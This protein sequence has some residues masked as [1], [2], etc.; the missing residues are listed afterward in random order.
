MN[1]KMGKGDHLYLNPGTRSTRILSRVSVD[2]VKSEACPR[3][4]APRQ[5]QASSQESLRILSTPLLGF[6]SEAS[7][8][9]RLCTTPGTSVEVTVGL[10]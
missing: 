1:P 7:D 4:M 5:L 10:K 2:P 6:N 9:G 3:Y 8:L